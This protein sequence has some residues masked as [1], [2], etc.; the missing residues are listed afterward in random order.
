MRFKAFNYTLAVKTWKNKNTI[1]ILFFAIIIATIAL[2]MAY[3]K[4]PLQLKP[5]F[6]SFLCSTHPEEREHYP[7]AHQ[8]NSEPD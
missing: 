8:N 7:Y 3:C 1:Y 4:T 6:F 5:N 2:G